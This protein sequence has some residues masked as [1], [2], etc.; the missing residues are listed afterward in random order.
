LPR[1]PLSTRAYDEI[2][3]RILGG[4]WPAGTVLGE[5]P[6]ADELGMSKTPV[7]QALRLLRQQGL[8]EVGPHRQMLV[9]DLSA[10]RRAEVLE[11]RRA[12]EQIAVAHACQRM[13]PEEVDQLQVLL[14]RQG[15]A[16]EAGDQ[17]AFLELDEAF[18]LAVARGAGM[19]TVAELLGQM[20]GFVRLMQLGRVRSADE[21]RQVLAEHQELTSAIEARDE[22]RALRV[23]LRHLDAWAPRLS[24]Q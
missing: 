11:I 12:L 14:R 20:R 18:H 3:G 23:L 4:E 13:P 5:G 19:T 9:C 7:R 8:L 22:P 17:A 1:V 6:L 21:L 2:R 16:A 24:D 15:R 10:E